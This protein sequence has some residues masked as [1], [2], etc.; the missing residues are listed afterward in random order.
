MASLDSMRSDLR[1]WN[2]QESIW[3]EKAKKL[4]RRR[5]DVEAVKA[6]L[7][8]VVN[9][10]M[11]DVNNK[12]YSAKQK[13]ADSVGRYDG[14][15]NFGTAFEGKNEQGV[16]VDGNLTSADSELQRELNSINQQLGEA[17][18]NLSQAQ[19]RKNSLR[20]VIAEEERRQREEE[21]RKREEARKQAIKK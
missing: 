14:G 12:L 6:A 18:G 21:R 19:Q 20:T 5:N 3:S 16:G 11:D 2:N 9:R 7:N 17:E 15:G 4:K 10:N 13:L 1:Y 8:T